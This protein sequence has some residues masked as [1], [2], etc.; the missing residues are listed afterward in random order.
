VSQSPADRTRAACALALPAFPLVLLAS[1]LVVPT[2][3]TENAVQ[4]RAAAAHG[5]AWIAAALLELL[6]A[7]LL[8]FGVAAVTGAVRG[9]GRR[10]AVA[11]GVLGVLGSLGMAAISFR[12]AFVYGLADDGRS[13]ALHAL[14]RVDGAVGP[15]VLPLMFAAPI[16][17]VLLAGAAARA[18]IAPRWLPAGA[19]AFFVVDMLPL[20]AAEELQGLLGIA[21]LATLARGLLRAQAPPPHAP[22]AALA[23]AA[24]DA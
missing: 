21:T 14:D 7:A 16:A 3:S 1:A 23:V 9:R 19:F 18:A 12:H 17:I 11:G 22:A 20:P 13:G 6:A 8:P 24:A 4:L 10:L 2:D 15:I 5:P